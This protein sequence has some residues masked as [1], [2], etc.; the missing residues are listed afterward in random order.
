[1]MRTLALLAVIPLALS[2]SCAKSSPDGGCKAEDMAMLRKALPT[3]DDVE[4][5][6]NM[7]SVGLGEACTDMPKG[8]VRAMVE[9]PKGDP[10]QRATIYAAAIGDNMRF[11]K[12]S[13]PDA[14]KIFS[15][16]A[17]MSPADRGRAVYQGCGYA[18][19]DLVTEAEM[20]A[21]M[22]TVGPSAMVAASVFV[23]L[24]DHGMAKTEA[25]SL[26]RGMMAVP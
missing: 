1:M 10:A 24:T 18:K 16:M 12:L 22:Q 5:R 4:T 11:T 15:S 25:K 13:C 9:G 8:I 17:T 26:A 2:L 14:E 7:T 6:A 20:T 19:L 3:I 23:W 21:A